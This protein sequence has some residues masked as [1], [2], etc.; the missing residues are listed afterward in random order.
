MALP[1]PFDDILPWQCQGVRVLSLFFRFEK[2][3]YREKDLHRRKKN[4]ET[5]WVLCTTY[6]CTSV[7][8]VWE[9]E[10]HWALAVIIVGRNI[11]WF[12]LVTFLSGMAFFFLTFLHGQNR[13]KNEWPFS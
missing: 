5:V 8:G 7:L 6:N 1:F 2:N 13:N 10:S 4:R 12:T 3:K 9:T 11:Y